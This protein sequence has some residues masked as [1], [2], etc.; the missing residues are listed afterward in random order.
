MSEATN[1]TIPELLKDAKNTYAHFERDFLRQ[2]DCG[3][4]PKNGPY[5][6]GGLVDGIHLG[7]L[8]RELDL[9]DDAADK[10]I[11][12]L[13][14][15]D[16]I[17]H[18]GGRDQFGFPDYAPTERGQSAIEAIRSSIDSVNRQLGE[19]LSA[20]EFASFERALVAINTIMREHEAAHQKSQD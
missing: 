18:G 11:F 16:Y 13:L 19:R 3:D 14:D 4:L 2:V 6:V 5:V 7:Q 9:L 15:R 12:N 20:E 17:E 10:L 8:I 1:I